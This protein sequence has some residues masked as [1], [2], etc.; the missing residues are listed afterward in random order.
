[1]KKYN[2]YLPSRKE[3][4]LV[5]DDFLYLDDYQRELFACITA[6]TEIKALVKAREFAKV[7]NIPEEE[8]YAEIEE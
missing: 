6:E 2:I 8:L 7:R 4:G 3:R 5:K 1:M